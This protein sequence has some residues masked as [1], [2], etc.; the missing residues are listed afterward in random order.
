MMVDYNPGP[1]EDGP[2][3]ESAVIVY[4]VLAVILLAVLVGL[5]TLG[6]G[7]WTPF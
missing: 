7:L 1:E 2:H 3:N 4:I 6:S 5:C